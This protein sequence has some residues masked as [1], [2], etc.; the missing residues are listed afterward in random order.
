MMPTSNETVFLHFLVVGMVW[1]TRNSRTKLGLNM[2]STIFP[3]LEKLTGEYSWRGRKG[4]HGLKCSCYGKLAATQ[5]T[6]KDNYKRIG[7]CTH[8]VYL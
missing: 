7:L 6:T 8:E 4:N 3:Y 5:T 1:W 2:L